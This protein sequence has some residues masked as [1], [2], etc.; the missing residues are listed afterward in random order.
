MRGI[1]AACEGATLTLPMAG[2]RNRKD[3]EDQIREA[4]ANG[5]NA[6]LITVDVAALGKRE[7]DAKVTSGGKAVKKDGGIASQS[8]SLYDGRRS[9]STHLR[10][11]LTLFS[12]DMTWAD[13]A[14]VQKHA[15]GIPVL[16][17]GIGA[18]EDVVLA[19]KHGAAGV[20]LSNHVSESGLQQIKC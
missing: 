13:I 12:A 15:P 16:V 10:P 8:F 14:W 11:Q 9:I 1:T 17:K 5:A 4:V 6:I 18:A 7:A 3:S 20:I 2:R 19:K